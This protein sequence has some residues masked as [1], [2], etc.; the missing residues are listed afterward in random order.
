MRIGMIVRSDNTGLGNQTRELAKMLK[1]SK[2][3]IINS[4]TFNRNVQHPEWY[5]NYKCMTSSGV[6]STNIIHNF[7]RD[8]DVL[9]TCETFYNDIIVKRARQRGITTILQYN[10]EFL[11][12]LNISGTMY[13]PDVLVSPSD[14]YFDQV[15]DIF[16][17]TAKIVQLPPPSRVELFEDAKNENFSKDHKRI[18]HI[19]GKAAI[20]DRNGTN[21]LFEMLKYSKA[22]Y[23]LVIKSQTAL[24]NIPE[25]PRITV[26]IGDVKNRQDMYKGFDAMILPRR[27]AGLCLPM[28]EALLSGLPVFMTDI[29]PNNAVLPSKWLAKSNK[30]DTLQTQALIDVYE[31]DP[32]ELANIVDNYINSNKE[33]EKQEAFDIGFNNFSVE[34]LQPQYLDLLSQ[35]QKDGLPK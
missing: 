18:L 26:E 6:P 10:Y 15:R 16:K 3:L 29:S 17:D 23:E 19:A 1:P 2:V 21:T 32:R 9:I 8:I 27:Y 11:K 30:I 5:S 33:K 20:K 4:Y 28:N 12:N 7:L 31:A 24:Q 22:D 13:L 34:K 25:D 14:W 35:I